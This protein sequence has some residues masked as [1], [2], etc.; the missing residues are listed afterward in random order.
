[1]RRTMAI[2]RPNDFVLKS[3]NQTAAELPLRP[4]RPAGAVASLASLAQFINNLR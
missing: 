1:M 2:I 4:P 3:E